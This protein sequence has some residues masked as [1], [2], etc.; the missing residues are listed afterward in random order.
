MINRG[1]RRGSRRGLCLLAGA[2]LWMALGQPANAV[3][4]IQVYNAGIAAPGQFAIQQH[5]NYIGMG[6]KFQAPES[7]SASERASAAGPVNP[8]SRSAARLAQP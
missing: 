1:F 2:A 4:D 6:Y 5:L 3:D 8:M 7:N